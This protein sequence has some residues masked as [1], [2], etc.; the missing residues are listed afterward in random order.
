VIE[1][2]G[3]TSGVREFIEKLRSDDKFYFT[4]E[5]LSFTVVILKL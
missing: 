2:T 4:S 3:F 1:K 5:V